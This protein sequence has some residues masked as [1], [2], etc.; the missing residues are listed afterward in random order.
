[1]NTVTENTQLDQSSVGLYNKFQVIRTDGKG[2]PGQKHEN[3]QYFV[4]NLTTDKHA[5]PALSAYAKSCNE[6]HPALAVDLRA[7]IRRNDDSRNEFVLVPETTLPNGTVVPSFMVGKYAC[8]KS[9]SDTAIVVADR[10]PWANINFHNAKKACSEAGFNLITELQYLAIAY[11]ITQQDI[12]WTGGKV[13]EGEV[14]RGLHQ[15]NVSAAQDGLYESDQP[16]ERRWHKL[17]NDEVVY[18]FS[19]NIYSWVFD[20]VQGDEKGVIAK[21]FADDSPTKTTAPYESRTHGMGDTYVGTDWSGGALFRGGYWR[22]GDG[23]GVFNVGGGWPGGDYHYV[24]FRCT[25]SL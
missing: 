12:N 5:M 15:D 1:M 13:G 18:D 25:K 9:D 14:F 2:A 7:I 6:E 8:S 24:G 17:A 16:I 21:P 19:G 20:D 22:S 3:D 4:L 10:K 11:Q 23:A